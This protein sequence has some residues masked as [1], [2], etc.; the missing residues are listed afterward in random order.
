MARGGKREGAGRPAG[1]PNKAT[2]IVKEAAQAFT[3]DAISTLAEI[4]RS[5]EHPAAA[6]VSAAN[7]LLDRGHGKPKQPLTGGDD[8]DNPIGVDIDLSG[9]SDEQLSALASIPG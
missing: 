7:A 8:D 3:A 9:L 6:R 4:M 2:L 1:S 5:S